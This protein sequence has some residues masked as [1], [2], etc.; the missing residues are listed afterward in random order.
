MIV[1]KKE[2]AFFVRVGQRLE[3]IKD[4]LSISGVRATLVLRSE[5][6]EYQMMMSDDDDIEA[7]IKL[8]RAKTDGTVTPDGMRGLN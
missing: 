2:E 5:D 4:E 1:N 3:D 6:G 7:V 8:I